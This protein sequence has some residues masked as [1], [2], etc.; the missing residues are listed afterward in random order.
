MA[1]NLRINMEKQRQKK[2]PPIIEKDRMKSFYDKKKRNYFWSEIERENENEEESPFQFL[3]IAF[4]LCL[5]SAG[6]WFA[7]QWF[8]QND[9]TIIPAISPQSETYRI[10]PE[11]RGG[12]AVPYQD[13]MIYDPNKNQ[14]ERVM[15]P[16][17]F[18]YSQHQ[19]IKKPISA[20]QKQ[21]QSPQINNNQASQQDHSQLNTR[22][23]PK[24]ERASLVQAKGFEN[25]NSPHDFIDKQTTKIEPDLFN[26]EDQ[27]FDQNANQSREGGASFEQ[28]ED[29]K[30]TENDLMSEIQD[31]V[32][33]I[34]LGF[35]KSSKIAARELARIKKRHA[36]LLL[37]YDCEIQNLKNGRLRIL[38]GPFYS[39]TQ[40]LS[41]AMRLGHRSR[42]IKEQ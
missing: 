25:N 3:F 12:I 32:F 22:P 34:Q 15:Q 14:G 11:D 16:Q 27:S 18:Y 26:N 1:A 13:K 19:E 29:G 9:N 38:I 40:A 4:S 35:F 21:E 7:Y 20:D 23:L 42:V 33:Q 36:R 28:K 37:D 30:K 8:F 10:Q 5:F 6:G 17:E 24:D 2:S 41:I 39:R 31:D